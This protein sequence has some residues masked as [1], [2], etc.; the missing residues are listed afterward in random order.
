MAEKEAREKERQKAKLFQI[1]DGEKEI[2]SFIIFLEIED[3]KIMLSLVA[4]AIP[5]IFPVSG[6]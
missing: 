3:S 2:G 4:K 5:M 1:V 6:N